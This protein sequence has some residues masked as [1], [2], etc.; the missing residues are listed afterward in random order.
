MHKSESSTTY[1][2]TVNDDRILKACVMPGTRVN[3]WQTSQTAC[4]L[5]DRPI[6]SFFYELI[7][8]L[9]S[10]LSAMA[11]DLLFYFLPSTMR[12]FTFRFCFLIYIYQHRRGWHCTGFFSLS[13]SLIKRTL[14]FLE[15]Q[16]AERGFDE[17]GRAS[18]ELLCIMLGRFLRYWFLFGCTCERCFLLLGGREGGR[19]GGMF[20]VEV[21]TIPRSLGAVI[22]IGR[23]GDQWNCVFI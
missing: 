12:P 10:F 1:L 7:F 16:N 17:K 15:Q 22:F 6:Q 19:Q 9:L 13:H 3:I 4:F 8:D 11:L 18:G 21:E 23:L 14:F 20:I 2:L 5:H